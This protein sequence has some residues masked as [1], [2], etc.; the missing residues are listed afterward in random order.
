MKDQPPNS[1]AF[2]PKVGENDKHACPAVKSAV[3]GDPFFAP[4]ELLP[5]LRPRHFYEDGGHNE[6]YSLW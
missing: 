3:S 6:N 1:V 2:F 4:Y 5:R